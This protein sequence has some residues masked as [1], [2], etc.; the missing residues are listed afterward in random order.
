MSDSPTP[1]RRTIALR[2]VVSVVLCVVLLGSAA[3]ALAVI[4]NTEPQAQ[5][6][7]A[8]RK[9]A[10][11]VEVVTVSR[12]TY[13]PTL[14]VLGTVRPVDDV[15]LGP[16]VS[17]EVV[18]IDPSFVPGGIV[19]KGRVL[20]RLDPADY[21]AAVAMRQSEL[22]QA[23]A[24]LSIEQ[25]RQ[26]AARV[27]YELLGDDVDPGNRELM[28]REQQVTVSRARIA[29]AEA[30][31]RQARLNLDRTDIRAPFDAKIITRAANLGSQVSP[32]DPLAR[33]VGIDTYWVELTV[34][35]RDLHRLEF[36][37]GD[38]EA[39][40]A[41]GAAVELRMPQS[42]PAGAMRRG[43]LS[44]LIGEVNPRTRMARV[45]VTVADP[46]AREVDAADSDVPPL[47]LGTLVQA[48]I[49]CR[50]LADVV[51]LERDYLR[52]NDTVWVMAEGQLEV[53]DVQVRARDERYV[54]IGEGLEAGERVV[55]TPL[56]TVAAGI[57]LRVEGEASDAEVD[58]NANANVEVDTGA[59]GDA[60]PSGEAEGSDRP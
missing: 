56:A 50:P 27:E 14:E 46:L 37:D 7:G 53:R 58:A 43:R 59:E 31:L 18:A 38:D 39:S 60:S 20:V 16:R 35:L 19:A 52:Q 11:L 40:Q 26:S 17:G 10:A 3:G 47:I 25:G 22:D 24:D 23:R 28:L 1:S 51:R 57:P 54:Y 2:A 44:R 4:F 21:E 9:S 49:A 41:E 29:A 48:R 8:T 30:M 34:P 32:G 33:L 15:T 13:R 45:L 55:T 36:P 5:R 12:G 42:W 6:S